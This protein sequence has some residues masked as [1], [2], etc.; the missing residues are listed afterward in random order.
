MI[1]KLPDQRWNDLEESAQIQS[2]S[3]VEAR[4][5]VLDFFNTQL[6][7]NYYLS[8]QDFELPSE[9]GIQQGTRN[10]HEFIM[11]LSEIKMKLY[12]PVKCI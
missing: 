11:D 4:L 2:I 9:N 1:D 8:V 12:L 6:F 5:F 3:K 10:Y 7:Q